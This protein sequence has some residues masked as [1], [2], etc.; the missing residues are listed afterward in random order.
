MGLAIDWDT[1]LK[2]AG[3]VGPAMAWLFFS[4][5]TN[6]WKR[7]GNAEQPTL[8][9]TLTASPHWR[10]H[11]SGTT[12][13]ACLGLCLLGVRTARAQQEDA[14]LTLVSLLPADSVLDGPDAV[15]RARL[16]Y[17]IHRFDRS[18]QYRIAPEYVSPDGSTRLLPGHQPVAGAGGYKEL[19]VR[20]RDIRRIDPVSDTLRLFF[21]L[22]AESRRAGAAPSRFSI[23]GI[24]FQF[25]VR[26]PQQVMRR[27][28]VRPEA[29]VSHEQVQVRMPVRTGAVGLQ[30]GDNA[31]GAAMGV[32]RG[33][34][35]PGP[36]GRG[37]RS[38]VGARRPPGDFRRP[39]HPMTLALDR[40]DGAVP[41]PYP[42]HLAH[43]NVHIRRRPALR[44]S[45]PS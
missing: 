19:V 38:R 20:L 12:T 14:S 28:S 15:I 5:S 21:I 42:D 36:S 24:W 10:Q 1:F 26:E 8:Q 43:D 34:N 23:A 44:G 17:R 30:A 3:L 4:A 7:A 32:R 39:R 13:V 33:R 11:W 22:Y 29:A 27:G 45:A 37:A 2:S 9:Q 31:P 6:I 18:L 16:R 25:L 41:P 35:G 40:R